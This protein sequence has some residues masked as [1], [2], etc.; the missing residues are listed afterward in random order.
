[1]FD[2][3]ALE[4][5]VR[6]WPGRGYAHWRT[7]RRMIGD[8]ENLLEHDISVISKPAEMP[9]PVAEFCRSLHTQV[10]ADAIGRIVGR[11]DLMPDS[12]LQWSGIIE[13]RPGSHQLIHSDALRHPRE[14]VRKEFTVLIYLNK[15]WTPDMKGEVE[16]WSDD[17]GQR[18]AAV[19]PVFNRTFIF[20]CTDTSHHGVPEVR[21][22]RKMLTLSLVS[23]MDPKAAE[24]LRARALFKP[25]PGDGDDVRRQGE[26]RL[27]VT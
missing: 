12:S 18:V 22:D 19:A 2:D 1:M 9:A 17:M 13:M 14:P 5:V 27:I 25:R 21:F 16:I 26:E 24:G 6:A 7:T 11:S 8:A 23:R 3:S 20:Q 10:F 15:G 4:A